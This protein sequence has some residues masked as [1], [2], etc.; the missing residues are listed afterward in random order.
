MGVLFNS[1]MVSKIL[2]NCEQVRL[3]IWYDE[4]VNN[5]E[6]NQ[7][8]N[9]QNHHHTMNGMKGGPNCMVDPTC[10]YS[11]VLKENYRNAHPGRSMNGTGRN[12]AN[13][14]YRQRVNNRFVQEINDEDKRILIEQVQEKYNKVMNEKQVWLQTTGDPD[15]HFIIQMVSTNPTSTNC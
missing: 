9:P 6:F 13:I 14:D 3:R 10:N 1:T 8:Y 5:Q 7:R 15:S 11:I 12:N 2:R 4:N